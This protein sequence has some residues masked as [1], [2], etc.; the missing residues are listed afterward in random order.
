MVLVK[1]DDESRLSLTEYH[2]VDNIV[3]S[4]GM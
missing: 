2:V 1:I 3:R 4:V